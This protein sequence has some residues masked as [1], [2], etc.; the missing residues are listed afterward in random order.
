MPGRRQSAAD[1]P[2]APL[3]LVHPLAV[4]GGGVAGAEI[5]SDDLGPSAV[6]LFRLHRS[7]LAWTADP[8]NPPAFDRA[9]LRR[10]EDSVLSRLRKDE[11]AAPLA[12]LIA[13]LLGW[14][15]IDPKRFA[16]ACLCV[17]D[18]AIGRGAKATAVAYAQLAALSWPRHARYAWV[19]ARLLF[20]QTRFREA[21]PW[22]RR[23]HRVG[24][25]TDDWEIQAKSLN[26]LGLVYFERGKFP[27]A[28]RLYQRAI[29]VARRRGLKEL[30]AMA[31]HNL[32]VLHSGCRE[33]VAAEQYAARAFELYCPTH[34]RLP[35]LVADVA[36]FWNEHGYY[37]RTLPIFRALA[38]R[39][40]EPEARVRVAAG[41]ARA[42]GGTGD[43]GSFV[44]SWTEVSRFAD[45]HP[46]SLAA[47]A[48]FE[49]AIGAANLRDFKLAGQI[50]TRT[51]EVALLSGSAEM[52][53][54]AELGLAKL[55][56]NENLDPALRRNPEATHCQ[57][58]DLL[59]QEFIHSLKRELIRAN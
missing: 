21:E 38:Q 57:P 55:E 29:K 26:S 6:L 16:W 31:T 18:W 39:F 1:L 27:V 14:E 50:L 59:A 44:E 2:R 12:V 23:A 42:A 53:T 54:A 48:L 19:V 8:E 20:G 41:I 47:G 15:T 17:S 43:R 28:K 24:V 25:W 10:I 56:R 34:P 11:I 13:A 37:R 35:E 5:L 7:L 52:A 40:T 45:E 36:L 58:A 30:E 46:S 22:Y 51:L 3:E 33:L 32:F 9:A 49:A 4:Q